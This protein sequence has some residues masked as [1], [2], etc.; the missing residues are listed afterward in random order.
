MLTDDSMRFMLNRGSVIQ[1]RTMSP[2]AWLLCAALYASTCDAIG[3]VRGI[4]DCRC[5]PNNILDCPFRGKTVLQ[6]NELCISME[7]VNL[8]QNN[9]RTFPESMPPRLRILDV[10]Q[11]DIAAS[12]PELRH[13]C[14]LEQLDVS[15]N[16]LSDF[17]FLPEICSLGLLIA[18]DNLISTIT[19]PLQNCS[20]LIELRLAKNKIESVPENYFQELGSLEL[21]DMSGNPSFV[22]QGGEFKGLRKLQYLGLKSNEISELP[23]DIFFDLVNLEIL[24]LRYNNISNLPAKVFR[25]LEKLEQLYLQRNNLRELP[26]SLLES[27]KALRKLVLDDNQLES[28][29]RDLLVRLHQLED[30][31]VRGN[32]LTEV[33]DALGRYWGPLRT[34][35][36]SDNLIAAPS[37]E[38]LR[39]LLRPGLQVP[40]ALMRLDS[41]L[42]APNARGEYE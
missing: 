12:T 11:N 35:L 18:T 8:Q 10:S 13:L 23:A 24:D 30:L 9:L 6:D 19:G 14:K 33:P 36:F 17:D 31:S 26:A 3:L 15:Y 38:S 28:L 1:K 32:R 42:F 7:V 25:S 29:P 22:L 39:P 2:V 20:R 41:N 21:L 27:Q 4:K 37:E 5:L 16:R 40:V 34:A